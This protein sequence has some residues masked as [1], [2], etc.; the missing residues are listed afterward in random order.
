MTAAVPLALSVWKAL[1]WVGLSC[2]FTRFLVQW[3]AS[4]RAG[5]SVTPRSFWWLSVCGAA[6]MTTV[7]W[8]DAH[9]ILLAGYAV[10]GAIFTRNLLLAYGWSDRRLGSVSAAV[11]ALSVVV[12][13]VVSQD[14]DEKL[15]AELGRGWVAI[16][17]LGQS[18]WGSRFAVQWWHAE[19][20]GRTEFPRSFWWLSLVGNGLMLAFTIRIGEPLYIA[21]Y[22]IGPIVQ[23]RNLMLGSGRRAA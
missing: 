13:A 9:P 6:L 14:L 7:S 4:E 5:R 21:G 11:L 19:R 20:T 12:F 18:I 8:I 3:I 10:N 17:L 2:F 22:T 1:G 23:V 16:G 15:V